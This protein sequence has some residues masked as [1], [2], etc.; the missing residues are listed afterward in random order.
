LYQEDEIIGGVSV[1]SLDYRMTQK[2]QEQVAR[3]VK[4]EIAVFLDR[5][6][7]MQARGPRPLRQ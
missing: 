5:Q 3:I 4:E 1:A 7:D 2:R 6:G